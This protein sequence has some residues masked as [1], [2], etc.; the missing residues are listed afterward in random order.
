LGLTALELK[1]LDGDA[2]IAAY[3]GRRVSADAFDEFK[4][5]INDYHNWIT[6]DAG[7][8][9]NADGVPPDAPFSTTA[10]I[11]DPNANVVRFADAS[12]TVSEAEGDSG[13]TTLTF[14]VERS[15]STSGDSRADV[16][17]SFDS[18]Y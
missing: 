4:A 15:G 16:S 1:P 13:T 18:G 9:Q 3:N 17:L 7:G 10:F 11:Y 14:T 5:P 2:D 8:N 12:L 6:Q